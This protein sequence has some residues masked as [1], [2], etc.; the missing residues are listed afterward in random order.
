MEE[1]EEQYRENHLPG[2][3][4]K[5]LFFIDN[6]IDI[7]VYQQ[8]NNEELQV[9]FIGRGSPQKRVH[10]VAGIAQMIHERKLPVKIQFCRGC[11]K[12]DQY[13]SIIPIAGFMEM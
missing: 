8:E 13:Q 4:F 1:V 7:P 6:A 9:F 10:L 2:P 3:Y 5:K 11:F 12:N